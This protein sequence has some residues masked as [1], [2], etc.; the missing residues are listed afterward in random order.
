MRSLMTTIWAL[1]FGFLQVFAHAEEIPAGV[2][3]PGQITI[4]KESPSLLVLEDAFDFGEISRDKELAHDFEVRNIG[5][6]AFD[7]V[8]VAV[9]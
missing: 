2:F 9:S 3:N 4:Q 1:F 8:K 5:E 6:K 7:I